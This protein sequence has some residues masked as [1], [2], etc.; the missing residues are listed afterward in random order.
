MTLYEKI[1]QYENTSL[2]AVRYEGRD[3]S[4]GK[5]LSYVRR[6]ARFLL[7][8]GIKEGDVV[9]VALPNVPAN[10]YF[11]YAIDAIGAIQNIIHPLSTLE[12]ML[13]AMKR[14]GSRQAILL[15]TAYEDNKTLLCSLADE[16]YTFFFVNP[17]HDA[18]PILRHAFYL[19]YKKAPKRTGFFHADRFRRSPEL[20]NVKSRDS[21]Q[22][23]VYLHSGGTTG[24]PKVIELSDDAFNNLADKVDGIIG[25][26]IRGK[27]ML[28]VLPSF[29]GFGLGMGIHSPLACG[30]TSLLMMKFNADKVIDEINRKKINMIIGV[31]LLYQ[32]LLKNPR[33]NNAALEVLD[34][35]FVGG[36]NV[37][38][39]LISAF[40][41]KMKQKGSGCMML[42]GYGLTETVTVCSVN[43]KENYR[44]GSVGKPLD[45][46]LA[47][48]LD[49]ELRPLPAGET[50]EVFISSNTEMNGYYSDAEA[51][52]RTLVEI[53]GKKWVRT[54]DLGYLD[55]DGFLFLRGRKKRMFKLSGI[56]VYPAQIE[57]ACVETDGVHNAALE[58]F[59]EPKPHT[60]LFLIKDKL[61]ERSEDEIRD[62]VM[63]SLEK[64]FLKYSL[65]K[66]I[67]FLD[68]FPE[69]KV[70]KI[71]HNAFKSI[72]WRKTQVFGSE[73]L[74][75][76]E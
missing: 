29:H 54:G 73:D 68:R 4:Y 33:F 20:Q 70:G 9:T 42:E 49:E 16:G 76:Q 55:A 36:D 67:L 71:D 22:S 12:Q 28:A 39:T 44:E 8:S 69:T 11:F 35:C 45:G 21:S 18:S 46:I 47:L 32:K 61:S 17:M 2:T 23:S 65:P 13:E 15:E 53:N 6:A 74:T 34:F 24:D 14:T 40:N 25:G 63:Q 37:L 1:K 64:R 48:V 7:D 51:T 38:P 59:E 60:V 75:N 27:S 19:K 10:V 56:N 58:F 26:S 66:K 52:E 72:Y 3:I 43:T 41:S 57:K 30:A 50:G 31:P 5:M 62:E